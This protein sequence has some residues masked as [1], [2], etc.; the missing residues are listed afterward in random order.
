M[1]IKDNFNLF[2][3]FLSKEV[4]VIVDHN[5][6]HVHVP[7][8]KD[9]TL[10]EDINAIYHVWTLPIA[11]MQKVLPV[12]C[13]TA[14]QF[15]HLILFQFGIYKEY[16]VLLKKIKEALVFFV[17]DIEIDYENKQLIVNDI[18]ITEDI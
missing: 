3:L 17:P 6:F 12:P 1:I 13:D 11:Q 15:I 9:F 7:A 2:N 10:N 5:F 16:A 4:K 18:I 14:F 8:V